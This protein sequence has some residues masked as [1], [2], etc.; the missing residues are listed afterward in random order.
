[1]SSTMREAERE[2]KGFTGALQSMHAGYIAV[3]AAGIGAVAGISA[4]VSSAIEGARELQ[5][6]STRL[7]V[8][9]E[10]LSELKFAAEQNNIAFGQLAIGMQRMTR[11]VAEAAQGM[12]EAQGALKELGLDAEQLAS[13][14]PDQQLNEVAEALGGV[15]NQSDKVRLAFKLFDS[16]GV[17]LLQLFD[18]L[19]GSLKDLRKDAHDLGV[20]MTD[21]AVESLDKA[22]RAGD[23]FAAA[24]KGVGQQFA[25]GFTEDTARVEQ[26]AGWL[27]KA[28]GAAKGFGEALATGITSWPLLDSIAGAVEFLRE[29]E[30]VRTSFRRDVTGGFYIP[31]LTI[32]DHAAQIEEM[33]AKVRKSLEQRPLI[34]AGQL[35]ESLAKLPE[36]T[37]T[38]RADTDK[39]TLDVEAFEGALIDM[40]ESSDTI[41]ARGLPA[42]VD[43]IAASFVGLG[44][45]AEQAVEFFRG[46]TVEQARLAAGFLDLGKSAEWTKDN[47]KQLSA[48]G[49]RIEDWVVNAREEFQT[50][51]IAMVDTAMGWSSA[52][53]NAMADAIMDTQS[54]AQAAAAAFRQLA[55][56]II[57]ELNRIIAKMVIANLI[58][59]FTGGGPVP[60]PVPSGPGVD[61]GGGVVAA[62]P[63]YGGDPSLAY[64]SIRRAPTTVLAP[65]SVNNSRSVNLSISVSSA[66]ANRGE[67]MAAAQ[68]IG[69]YLKESGAVA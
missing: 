15:K 30:R 44:T 38:V 19:G 22:A 23:R 4:V 26:I 54:F 18:S 67:S 36:A 17:G 48:T 10:S 33:R 7:G 55:R 13:M 16:E 47:I 37:V 21:E 69:R 61:I 46:M 42:G 63:V 6:F 12:G 45:S 14:L 41:L 31:E 40:G 27:T 2:S 34:D 29:S 52:W 43:E 8:S 53:G 9:A 25:I 62:A 49:L 60:V 51:G 11:R 39:A 20:T 50:L 64:S 68:T 66:F 65:S 28:Q 24:L 1:M 58:K 3:A 32:P 5:S 59:A 35:A 57:A 56:S